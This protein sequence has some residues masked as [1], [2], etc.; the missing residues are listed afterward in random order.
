MSWVR[1]PYRSFLFFINITF[2]IK[3][4]VRMAELVDALDLGSSIYLYG[5][6]SLY[7][8]VITN[9]PFDKWSKSS[10]FHGG[11]S[12]SNLLWVSL[13][14]YNAEW[15]N[16]KLV[17]FITQRLQVRILSPLFCRQVPDSV[18]VTYNPRG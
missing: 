15:S 4:N 11:V 3:R 6:K 9:G 17:G 18:K 12:S 16:W 5:F 8:H 1:I 10:P 13:L 7:G 2:K 14:Y